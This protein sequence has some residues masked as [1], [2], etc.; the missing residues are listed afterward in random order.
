MGIWGQGSLRERRPGV[1]EIRIAVGVDPVSGRTVQ[2]SF[3]FHGTSEDAEERRSELA[4]QFAEYRAVRRA[5]PFLTVG[6]LPP[7][8]RLGPTSRR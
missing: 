7:G 5:A 6:G 3:W 2:R 4:T 8:V 1:F